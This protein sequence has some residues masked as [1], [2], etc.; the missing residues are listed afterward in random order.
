MPEWVSLWML[1]LV[2]SQDDETYSP[3]DDSVK[4]Q[5]TVQRDLRSYSAY[6]IKSPTLRTLVIIRSVDT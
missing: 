3:L 2:A 4:R 6:V 5:V 1:P